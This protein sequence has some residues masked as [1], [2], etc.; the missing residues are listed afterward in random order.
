[1][2][3]Y[4]KQAI[5]HLCKAEYLGKKEPELYTALAY[6]Y[7]HTLKC[8]PRKSAEYYETVGKIIDVHEKKGNCSIQEYSQQKPRAEEKN[9]R[10]S[11]L[12]HARLLHLSITQRGRKILQ[13]T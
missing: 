7:H 11:I 1:M 2:L 3:A 9:G 4:S 8:L 12:V 13:L 10:M 5:Q 6:A